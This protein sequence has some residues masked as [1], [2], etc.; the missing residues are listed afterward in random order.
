ML[1]APLKIEILIFPNVSDIYVSESFKVVRIF[2]FF[3]DGKITTK[4]N[5]TN[6]SSDHLQ[7]TFFFIWELRNCQVVSNNVNSKKL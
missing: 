7:F 5:S 3:D 4:K 6:L 2:C 1:S